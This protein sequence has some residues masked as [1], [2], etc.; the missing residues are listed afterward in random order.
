MFGMTVHVVEALYLFLCL[1]LLGS[2]SV[3]D[4]GAR[5][6]VSVVD[7]RLLPVPFKAIPSEGKSVS[8]WL[9]MLDH[10]YGL[11][12]AAWEIKWCAE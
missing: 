8:L 12:V 3:C 2:V 1:D 4:P 5:T 6:M 7:M 10:S 9:S 11:V